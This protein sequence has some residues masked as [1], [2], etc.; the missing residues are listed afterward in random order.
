MNLNTE[1]SPPVLPGAPP[2]PPCYAILTIH[3]MSDTKRVGA[4]GDHRAQWRVREK[5]MSAPSVYIGV[6]GIQPK[7][8][9]LTLVS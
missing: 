7:S 9:N 8:S 4:G 1:S 3:T 6:E 5:V 2:L